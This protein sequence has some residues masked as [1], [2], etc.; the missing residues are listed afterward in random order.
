MIIAIRRRFCELDSNPRNPDTIV[1][2][3]KG[4]IPAWKTKRDAAMINCLEMETG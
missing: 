2:T 3:D 4:T 1:L